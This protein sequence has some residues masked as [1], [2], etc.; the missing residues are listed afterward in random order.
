MLLPDKKALE[1]LY[2]MK[3]AFSNKIGVFAD[4]TPKK[5]PA[6]TQ[7]GLK[8]FINLLILAW[9][10]IHSFSFPLLEAG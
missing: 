8:S 1:R 5:P 10:R 3:L 9:F 4:S 6:K 7:S 2:L